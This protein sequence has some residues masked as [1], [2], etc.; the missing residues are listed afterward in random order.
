M[1]IVAKCLAWIGILGMLRIAW[2]AQYYGSVSEP[3]KNSIVI[4]SGFFPCVALAGLWLLR[5]P[6][7]SMMIVGWTMVAILQLETLG[8]LLLALFLNDFPGDDRFRINHVC[9][10]LP[11]ILCAGWWLMWRMSKRRELQWES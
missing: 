7:M 4:L 11:I 9:V 3:T 6:S 8:V 5:R 10:T 1:Q 2:L